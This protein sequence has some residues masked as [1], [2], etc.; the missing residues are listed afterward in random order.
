M[1]Q[2]SLRKQSQAVYPELQTRS[3]YTAQAIPHSY[4]RSIIYKKR[5]GVSLCF[6]VNM[7]SAVV[8]LTKMLTSC[9]KQAMFVTYLRQ[10]E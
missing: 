3:T 7:S 6:D 10:L 2:L 1:L 5:I 8:D 4:S 9:T